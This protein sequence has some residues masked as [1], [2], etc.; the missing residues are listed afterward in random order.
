MFLTRLNIGQR[1]AAGFALLIVLML[2][3]SLLATGQLLHQQQ[4][5]NALHQQNSNSN[6]LLRNETLLLNIHSLL[7]Q[8]VLDK[9]SQSLPDTEQQLDTLH[10]QIDNHLAIVR[11][12][13]PELQAG[14]AAF[15]E[16]HQQWQQQQQ[17][18]IDALYND[19]YSTASAQLKHSAALLQ[20]LQQQLQSLYQHSRDSYQQSM[21]NAQQ[22][23]RNAVRWQ[24][25]LALLCLI[26]G[27]AAAWW[28]V[29]SITRP[30]AEL[31]QLADQL[32][33]GDLTSATDPQWQDEF[34]LLLNAMNDMTRKLQ[35][36]VLGVSMTAENIAGVSQ[37][38]D[39]SS[40]ELSRGASQQASSAEAIVVAM[41]QMSSIM[42]R[43]SSNASET[44]QIAR[45]A[46][47]TATNGSQTLLKVVNAVQE[48]A[49]SIQIIDDIAEQTNLLAINAEIEA[50]RAGTSGN[51]FAVVA[52]EVRKLAEAS[53][54]AAGHIS[55][56]TRDTRRDAEQASQLLNDMLSQIR[57]TA[58]LI[59]QIH[60]ASVEQQQ[61]VQQVD[62]AIH[63]LE[64]VVQKN[65]QGAEQMAVRSRE[66]ST[67]AQQLQNSVGF[68]RLRN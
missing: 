41:E 7:Q 13:L 31:V 46:A 61:S 64:Q 57:Q 4:Q 22:Q 35:E 42:L 23:Y 58:E 43:N 6:L 11:G 26:A 44:N 67:E 50:A 65:R 40:Q 18:L 17:W 60:E 12:R 62:V 63:K 45:R 3:L 2:L 34:G 20:T 36:T 32:A 39:Y 9:Q 52:G 5:A 68:F 59:S 28:L 19:E 54:Q 27:S 55:K 38:M 29:R 14:I 15:A 33:R 8:A 1:L 66:L 10:K 30:A 51:G 21:Q 25:L 37:N 47:D 48:M 53:Q 56:L 49:Q 16:A 24:L